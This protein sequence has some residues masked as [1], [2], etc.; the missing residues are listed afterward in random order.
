[1]DLLSNDGYLSGA[2]IFFDNTDICSLTPYWKGIYD[3]LP[4]DIKI[5]A[6]N[7]ME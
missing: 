6:K 4:D 1:M 3:T 5:R 2:K 7:K